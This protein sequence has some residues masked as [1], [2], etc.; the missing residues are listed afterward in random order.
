MSVIDRPLPAITSDN[1]PFWEAC[2]EDTLVLPNCVTCRRA[3][4]PPSPVCPHCFSGPPEWRRAT[5]KG[6][7]ST[8]VVVHQ[9][10]FP[11]F[12]RDLP[13]NVAQIELEEGP[14]I[15]ASVTHV[16]NVDLRIG[17]EVVVAFER[18][19]DEVTLPRFRPVKNPRS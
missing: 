17:L 12:E 8:F 7:V 3:Y 1:L 15:T 10:W 13:Y 18:V 4:W 9:A 5:G 2:R 19:N 16:E 11:A 14:R 6:F